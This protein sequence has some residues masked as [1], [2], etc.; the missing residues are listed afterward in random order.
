VKQ[1]FSETYQM[2]QM[3]KEA[4]HDILQEILGLFL[5]LKN[6]KIFVGKVLGSLQIM[7]LIKC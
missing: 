4:F 1:N 6:A 3:S 7:L 2:I 5:E